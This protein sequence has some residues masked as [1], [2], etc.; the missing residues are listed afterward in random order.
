M[1]LVNLVS[2]CSFSTSVRCQRRVLKP[3]GPGA[4]PLAAV[5]SACSISSGVAW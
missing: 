3:E 4:E 5:R 1:Q 2:N